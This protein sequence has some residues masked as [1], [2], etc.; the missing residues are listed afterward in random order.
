MSPKN[1]FNIVNNINRGT[2]KTNRAG[3]YS[4]LVIYLQRHFIKNTERSKVNIFPLIPW[5]GYF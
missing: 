5:I 2:H 3:V 4:I 1:I